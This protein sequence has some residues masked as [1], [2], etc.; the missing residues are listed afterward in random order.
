MGTHGGHEAGQ[1][2][3]NRPSGSM[4]IPL[5]IVDS[6][7]APAVLTPHPVKKWNCC[8]CTKFGR[9]WGYHGQ[10]RLRAEA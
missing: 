1:D 2:S 6:G 3:G 5:T 9:S 10:D 7:N 8:I 4:G